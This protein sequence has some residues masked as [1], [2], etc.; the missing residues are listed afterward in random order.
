[1]DVAGHTVIADKIKTV[2]L[3]EHFD[4]R[5]CAER[6]RAAYVA[7]AM[8]DEERAAVLRL[9]DETTPE[10]PP[11]GRLPDD[12][13]RPLFHETRYMDGRRV[14]YFKNLRLLTV[15]GKGVRRR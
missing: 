4:L 14:F 9:L 11:R 1:M 6:S 3:A 10:P 2:R 12:G 15:R 5:A 13:R 8:P 7:K